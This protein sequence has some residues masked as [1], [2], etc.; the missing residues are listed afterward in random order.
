MYNTNDDNQ[1]DPVEKQTNIT[2]IEKLLLPILVG[3]IFFIVAIAWNEA[4]IATIN[5]Y[6]SERA[7]LIPTGKELI[8]KW[9]YVSI[10]TVI[11]IIAVYMS[12]NILI[13]S[14]TKLQSSSSIGDI[15]PEAI[16]ASP[17]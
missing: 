13:G 6:T 12:R 2:L 16:A 7:Y 11:L 10:V 1:S 9:V 14:V 5:Y 3:I 15:T 8:Y 4:I 17:I